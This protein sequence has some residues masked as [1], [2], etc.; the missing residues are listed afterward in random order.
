MLLTI[1]VA[2]VWLAI[3]AHRS[4]GR[5]PDANARLAIPDRAK[6]SPLNLPGGG[7]APAE[8]YE[9]Y[10]DLYRVPPDE[11]LVIAE[12]S[13]IDIPQLDGS[14][15]HASTPAEEQMVRDFEAANHQKHRWDRRFTNP[16]YH[17]VPQP[18][19][20]RIKSCLDTSRATEHPCAAY[21]GVRHV[22]YLGIPGFNQERTRAIVSV[23]RMCGAD[24][25]SG[26]IFEVKKD[27]GRWV[28][29][30]NT[31]FT[32]DCSWMY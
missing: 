27:G 30:E 14:C 13:V 16:A 6:T 18:E 29:A 7:A 12:D 22:R 3:Q 21:P 20:D 19:A 2:M 9:V 23:I 26:G 17:L 24:C 28:R 4:A 5:R 8:A 11:P 31:A 10:S 15:L 1:A 25:G 32:S